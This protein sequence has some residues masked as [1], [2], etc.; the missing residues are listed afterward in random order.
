MTYDNLRNFLEPSEFHIDI[1]DEKIYITNYG[2][3]LTLNSNKIIIKD[4]KKKII[5][6]GSNFSL[7]K[8]ATKELLIF[9]NLDNLE[10]KYE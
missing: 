7:N 1:Y 9:G 8:L 6:E 4:K 3:I 5:L 10:I 2:K